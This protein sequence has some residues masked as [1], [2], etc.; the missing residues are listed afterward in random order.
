M[1]RFRITASIPSDNRDRTIALTN[2][3]DIADRLA[4]IVKADYPEAVVVIH[5]ATQE[6]FFPDAKG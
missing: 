1:L 4:E 5:D 2:Y 6:R 3:Q